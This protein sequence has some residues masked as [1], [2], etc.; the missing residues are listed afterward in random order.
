[1]MQPMSLTT[2][3]Q[4]VGLF[5]GFSL[6][7]IV[8]LLFTILALPM[9]LRQNTNAEAMCCAIEC[10]LAEM[11]GILFMTA[12]GLPALYAVFAGEPLTEITYVGLLLVFAV[13]G[14]L[15]LWH[16]A[17]LRSI[18]PAAKAFPAAL[19]HSTWK[20]LGLIIVT[21]TS[22]SLI[23]RLMLIEEQAGPWWITHMIMLL[24]GLLISWFTLKS[25]AP[26]GSTPQKPAP[27]PI[28][29]PVRP[30]I[31]AP[32]RK[33]LIAVKKPSMKPKRR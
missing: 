8:L 17:R 22:L 30:V 25:P 5:Y 32:V 9:F 15:F 1:M 33:G 29:I 10:Y 3:F 28:T 2:M 12:G 21:F 23:L 26:R 4:S 13:G 18:D 31:A 19:F 16:D 11:L 27:R 7:I 6:P 14:L 20:F 24:Y